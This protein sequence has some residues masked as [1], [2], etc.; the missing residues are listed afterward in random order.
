MTLD[1]LSNLQESISQTLMQDKW[2]ALAVEANEDLPSYKRKTVDDFFGGTIL[3]LVGMETGYIGILDPM[4]GKVLHSV[5]SHDHRVTSITCF[6]SDNTVV[7]TGQ[8]MYIEKH[9][10]V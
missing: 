7:V 8:G 9:F 4:T 5:K 3:V 6:E 2:L 10:Q 1:T